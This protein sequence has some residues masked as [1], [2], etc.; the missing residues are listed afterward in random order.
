MRYRKQ[1]QIEAICVDEKTRGKGIGTQPHYTENRWNLFKEIWYP[2]G[3]GRGT[4]RASFFA[5]P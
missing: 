4:G 3:H 1:L 2:E 5:Y